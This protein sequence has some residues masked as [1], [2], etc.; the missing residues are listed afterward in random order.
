MI[1]NFDESKPLKDLPD[2]AKKF[3]LIMKNFNNDK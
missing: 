2:C 3:D 1:L